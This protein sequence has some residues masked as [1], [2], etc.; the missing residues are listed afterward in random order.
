MQLDQRKVNPAV[1]P[2]GKNYLLNFKKASYA[3]ISS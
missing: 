3:I 1:T 2:D